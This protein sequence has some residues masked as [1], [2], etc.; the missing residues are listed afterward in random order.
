MFLDLNQHDYEK[1]IIPFIKNGIIID[2]SV[3]D[4]FIDGLVEVR[5]AKKRLEEIPEYCTLLAFFDLINIT[6]RFEKFFITPH[7]LT[8]VCTH[9]RIK[10][11]KRLDYKDI[12]D[13]VMPVLK[14]MQ[15]E[16]IGKDQ[17]FEQINYTRPV[18]EIG[19]ISIFVVAE[20]FLA[21]GKKVALLAKDRDLNKIYENHQNVMVMDYQ[22]IILNRL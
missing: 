4:I 5:I 6:N 9:F 12:V 22:S 18:I 10:Y 7:I 8:E 16:V 3:I 2:T 15:E 14:V 13:E 1:D 11:N 20:K 19:D 17:I 21:S